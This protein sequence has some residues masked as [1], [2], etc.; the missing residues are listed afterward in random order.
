MRRF[1]TGFIF[2]VLAF[3]LSNVASHFVNSSPLGRTDRVLFYGF[4]FAFWTEGG[5]PSV[6]G[7][8][9]CLALA[10]DIVVAAL[11]GAATGLLFVRKLKHEVS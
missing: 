1:I 7:E 11:C 9:D 4:P 5:L 6:E 3:G 10:G 2:G 8:L